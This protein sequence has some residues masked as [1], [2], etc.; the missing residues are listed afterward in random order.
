MLNLFFYYFKKCFLD[1]T[2]IVERWSYEQRW[3]WR[4]HGRVWIDD[5]RVKKA[6]DAGKEKLGKSGRLV[7]R[8]SGTEQLIR[9]MAE[10]DDER[11]VSGVVGDIAEAVRLAER[12]FMYWASSKITTPNRRC[13][14]YFWSRRSDS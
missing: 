3:T 12:F 4:I 6:I 1:Q 14:K 5:V 8:P 2:I 11:L 10:G 13:W 9:V 7:I